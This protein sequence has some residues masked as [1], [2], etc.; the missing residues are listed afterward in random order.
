MLPTPEDFAKKVGLLGVGD[1]DR[2]VVYDRLYGGAA[3]A[4]VWWMFRVFGYDKVAM[5]DGGYGKWTK[6]KLPTDMAMVRPE[7]G[8]FSA[9]YSPA[10]VRTL[11]EMREKLVTDAAQVIAGRGP[12]KC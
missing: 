3:A 6:E 11:G 10:L 2:V 9:T 1:G 8:S 4:R 12:S 7:Q 5:L